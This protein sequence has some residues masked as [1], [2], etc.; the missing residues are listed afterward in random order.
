MPTGRILSTIMDH[1]DQIFRMELPS[2]VLLLKTCLLMYLGAL[3]LDSHML[4]I[5]MSS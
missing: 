5:V 1:G 4:V 2:P 3:F